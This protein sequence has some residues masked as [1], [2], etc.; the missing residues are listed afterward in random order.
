MCPHIGG[1]T[2]VFF[3][4]LLV[5]PP[6]HFFSPQ[7]LLINDVSKTKRI[8]CFSGFLYLFYL[9]SFST[10]Q[11]FTSNFIHQV[12]KGLMIEVWDVSQKTQTLLHF[13]VFFF[14]SV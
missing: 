10:A 1:D 2:L 11:L 9:V 6:S 5:Y 8:E 3:M 14:E 12:F 4:L 7:C 13:C